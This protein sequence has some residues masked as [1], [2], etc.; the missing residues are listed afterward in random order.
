MCGNSAR[1][2]LCGG[3]SAMIVPTATS[4]TPRH[5]AQGTRSDSARR[6]AQDDKGKGGA[7]I[8]GSGDAESTAGPHSTSLRAGSPLRYAPVGMTIHIWVQDASAQE[9]LPSRKRSQ[10]LSEASASLGRKTFPGKIRGRTS[11]ASLGMTKGRATLPLREVAGQKG[12]FHLLRW[13]GGPCPLVTT[14][15]ERSAELQIPFDF[16]QGRLSTS[17]RPYRFPL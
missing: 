5:Q 4:S 13:A 6:S 3:R 7:S 17:L 1:T 11:S 14:F 10:A 12:V 15:Q 8:H 9:K 2:D 16:A